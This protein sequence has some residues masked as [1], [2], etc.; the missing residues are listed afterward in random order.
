MLDPLPINQKEIATLKCAH[1]GLDYDNNFLA[2]EDQDV[3]AD[4]D[5]IELTGMCID[6][7]E[8]N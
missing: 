7:W 8:N 1:C 4:F 5:N 2:D 6:C 3:G